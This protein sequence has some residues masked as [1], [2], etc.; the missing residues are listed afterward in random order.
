VEF[1]FTGAATFC[2]DIYFR[3]INDVVTMI[4]PGAH[5]T[6]TGTNAGISVTSGTIPAPFV[7][8]NALMMP[9]ITINQGE[10]GVGLIYMI[11]GDSTYFAIYATASLGTF[12]GGNVGW[13]TSGITYQA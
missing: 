7:P 4:I 5:Q 13:Q 1:C 3:R 2:V 9:I 8:T 6:W 11:N 12:T 10:Q